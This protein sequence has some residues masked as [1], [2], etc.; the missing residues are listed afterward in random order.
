MCEL[1]GLSSYHDVPISFTWRGFLGK[2]R[3]HRHGWGVAWYLGDGVGLIKEPKP[4]PESPIARL[5][6]NGI[7]SFC[8][9]KA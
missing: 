6:V 9:G 3:I 4:S 5:L 2:G 8:L 1:F 7:K